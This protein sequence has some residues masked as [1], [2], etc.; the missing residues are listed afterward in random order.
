MTTSHYYRSQEPPPGRRPLK[1]VALFFVVLFLLVG[2]LAGVLV[3]SP[4]IAF[5]VPGK[6]GVALH[7]FATGVRLKIEAV[8]S[9]QGVLGGLRRW[10]E[11]F[12]SGLG[13]VA[14]RRQLPVATQVIPN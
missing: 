3:L 9:D 12:L 7:D 13:P 6:A 2:I 8:L 10:A 11:P 14:L 5:T 4:D 1:L